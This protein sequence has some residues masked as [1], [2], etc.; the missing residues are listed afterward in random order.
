M[1][2][3]SNSEATHIPKKGA[4]LNP[5]LHLLDGFRGRL[6]CA[7]PLETSDL[8]FALAGRQD[9]KVYALKLF[10]EGWAE[11]ILLSTG[12]WDIRRF[13]DLNLT[14]WPQLWEMRSSTPP[15]KRHFFVSFDGSRWH[16]E[17]IPIRNF[18]T[19]SELQALTCWLQEH[20]EIRSVL[21]VSSGPHL[22]RVRMCCRE[23]L[24]E[25]VAHRLVAVP[26]D[27]SPA[28]NASPRTWEALKLVS[29]EWFKLLLYRVVLVLHRAGK[30]PARE[31]L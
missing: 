2:S 6:V 31:A 24:A 8:I 21:V 20:P 28:T 18:G 23:L 17:R 26:A 7:D 9:R 19:L 15:E 5:F 30:H 14:V 22:R 16:V 10:Q 13:A 11:R 4:K 3:A 1:H 12:R 25:R 27:I 29:F